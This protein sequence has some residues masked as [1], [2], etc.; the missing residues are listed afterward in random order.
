MVNTINSK[1]SNLITALRSKGVFSE[2][3]EQRVTNVKP[4]TNYD[5]NELILNLIARKSQSDFSDFISALRDSYH[6]HVAMILNG[7]EFDVSP[8]YI[9]FL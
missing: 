2:Y 8:L 9:Y 3:D 6:E 1:S 7:A 5:R 4:D